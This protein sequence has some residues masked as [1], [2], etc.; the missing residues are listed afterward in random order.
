MEETNPLFRSSFAPHPNPLPKGEG[1]QISNRERLT[2]NPFKF[3]SAPNASVVVVK[4]VWATRCASSNVTAS[5]RAMISSGEM[6]R[7]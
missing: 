3:P 5:M 2:E 4:Q 7:P 1:T 6:R